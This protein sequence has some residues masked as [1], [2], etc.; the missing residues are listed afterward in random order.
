M[1]LGV[2]SARLSVHHGCR[3]AYSHLQAVGAV[4]L[5]SRGG[6]PRLGHEPRQRHCSCTL[7]AMVTTTVFVGV[8]VVV[9]VTM[10]ATVHHAYAGP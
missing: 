9:T 5:G 8:T 10:Y 7:T 1:G 2:G 4:Y 6:P 3:L